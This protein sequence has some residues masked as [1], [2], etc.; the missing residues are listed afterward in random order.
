MVG[1]S[2]SESSGRRWLGNVVGISLVGS[3]VGAVA[4]GVV[5]ELVIGGGA[6]V[7]P[8]IS[9]VDSGT[10]VVKV[11]EV[12][13]GVMMNGWRSRVLDGGA[14]VTAVVST[15][16]VGVLHSSDICT[17]APTR[18]ATRMTPTPPAVNVAAV[19]RY[20]GVSPGS[21]TDATGADPSPAPIARTL[22]DR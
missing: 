7:S 16:L 18:P 12:S 6:S 9:V 22:D 11:V 14:E 1:A 21:L 3:G 19:V 20:Q 15:V 17:T 10:L 4:A 8:P 5:S 2:T 13:D